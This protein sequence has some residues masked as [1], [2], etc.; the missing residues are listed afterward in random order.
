MTLSRI[1]FLICPDVDAFRED[2]KKFQKFYAVVRLIPKGRVT[3]YGHIAILAG[4]PGRARLVGLALGSLPFKSTVPWQR[5]VNS[6][7][8]IS[9]R[10]EL[11]PERSQRRLLEKEGVRFSAAGV[12]PLE[13]FGWRGGAA[14]VRRG[15]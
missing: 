8:R 15:R 11:Y 7:G 6:Q 2:P 14:A 4:L 12:I 3:T 5:V 10:E 1:C 13:R 9:K